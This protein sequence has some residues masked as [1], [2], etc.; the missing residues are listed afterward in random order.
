MLKNKLSVQEVFRRIAAL[1]LALLMI[2]VLTAGSI[3]AEEM[4]KN[5]K[6][7]TVS[8]DENKLKNGF[9]RNAELVVSAL[10]GEEGYRITAYGIS[11]PYESEQSEPE[12]SYQD[13]N[14]F[15]L[16]ENGI[17]Y[18]CVRDEAGNSDMMSV[19]LEC[20]DREGPKRKDMLVMIPDEKNG[21]GRSVTISPVLEDAVGLS[22]NPYSY[23]GGKTYTSVSQN[24]YYE[25]CD[26]LLCYRDVLGNESCDEV[27]IRCI[28]RMPPVVSLLDAS[29]RINTYAHTVTCDIVASDEM[30]GL[31]E[32]AYS[33]NR[34]E[35]SPV[36]R[37]EFE[38]EG[39]YDLFVRD[40]LGNIT[41]KEF[42]A[43]N[44]DNEP[45]VIKK[46]TQENI[47][48]VN[49]YARS[50]RVSLSAVDDKAGLADKPYK[51][52]RGAVC[53]EDDCITCEENG[54]YEFSV[55]D[56]LGNE[57]TAV[58]EINTIDSLGPLLYVTGN[59]SYYVNGDITLSIA[60]SDDMSGVSSIWY[61]NNDINSKITMGEYLHLKNVKEKLKVTQNGSYTFYAQD[62]VGNISET[63]INVTKLD[64]SKTSSKSSSKS[65][66]VT[67]HSKDSSSTQ[68][69]L[70]LGSSTSKKSSSSSA[71]K[72][73]IGGS[74]SREIFSDEESNTADD[75][76]DEE[77][78]ED[79]ELIFASLSE[80]GIS[81]NS[82]SANAGEVIPEI[83]EGEYE[84]A[85]S[86][87]ESEAVQ[88]PEE[89]ADD[90]P[91]KGA[92][93]AIGTCII[94]FLLALVIFV[95]NRMGIINIRDILDN[96]KNKEFEENV[97]ETIG[98]TTD[99]M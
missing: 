48:E 78:Y 6:I 55:L 20:I 14:S 13:S 49:G 92:V 69:M 38:Q 19:Q 60:A 65:S 62:A 98:D 67:W 15:F 80:D 12:F 43:E 46:I 4:K 23:N 72:I 74:N 57:Q 85:F 17:Y 28:D 86:K 94:I 42:K 36:G 89:N 99:V 39:K 5:L 11:G 44:I 7:K 91:P 33:L 63:T 64:K 8:I 21:Y 25:N 88:F 1:L 32:N 53:V 81:I 90:M 51:Y 58:V 97:E 59:P 77:A 93:I 22:E 50:V 73:V 40:K 3:Y 56:A 35:W 10:Q 37:F 52:G 16:D 66:T 29:E 47:A 76:D 71:G 2:G 68:A 54:V 41:H 24:T 18:F 75:E 84:F 87:P 45:P 26:L 27:S 96:L 34:V 79:G 31:H 9:A 70:V 30:S 82:V 95:L 61:K 83:I